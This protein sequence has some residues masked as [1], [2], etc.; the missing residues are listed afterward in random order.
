[1]WK[2]VSFA[3]DCTQLPEWEGTDELGSLCS[4]CG[5]DYCEECECPGPTQDGMTYLEINGILY[6]KSNK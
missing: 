2:V 3:A 4:I 6:G 1:M 5:L